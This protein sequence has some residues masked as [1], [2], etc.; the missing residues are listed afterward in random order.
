MINLETNEVTFTDV[1][2]PAAN[3]IGEEGAAFKYVLRGINGDRIL[4]AAACIGDARWLIERASDYAK[5]RV[6]FDRPIGSNQSI[7]FP[8][9][10]SHASV[11]AADMM[12]FKAAVCYDSLVDC[13][14][15]AN[16]AKL[17]ASEALAEAANAA[18]QTYG[19]YAFAKSYDIERKFRESRLFLNAPGSSQLILAHIGQHVLGMPRSF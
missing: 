19:G 8:I 2:V 6:I 11:E 16:I 15:E 7:Q 3:L 1:R 14:A 13:G 17:L 18:M 12:R 5:R 9:A 4:A 10:H